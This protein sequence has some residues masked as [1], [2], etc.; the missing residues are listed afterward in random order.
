MA[1]KVARIFCCVA[2]KPKHFHLSVSQ[3]SRLAAAEHRACGGRSLGM[4]C[5]ACCGREGGAP[6]E[7][8]AGVV[9]AGVACA[10]TESAA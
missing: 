7:L 6:V 1:H 10:G 9:S 2:G 8:G 4:S 3:W 5:K